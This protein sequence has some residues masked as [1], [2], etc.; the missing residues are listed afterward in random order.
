MTQLFG[1]VL[2]C[3]LLSSSGTSLADVWSDVIKTPHY[4]EQNGSWQL[5]Y[6]LYEPPYSMIFELDMVPPVVVYLHGAP[7]LVDLED[8]DPI[9]TDL[10]LSGCVV[11]MPFYGGF[12]DNW[13]RDAANKTRQALDDI[14]NRRVGSWHPPVSNLALV[15]H[16]MG[17]MFAVKMAHDA[18][19]LQFPSRPRLVVLH[20][21]AGWV[22]QWLVNPEPGNTYWYDNLSG[23]HDQASLVLIAAQETWKSDSMNWFQY[24]SMANGSGVW[25]RAW[26]HTGILAGKSAYLVPGDHFSVCKPEDAAAYQAYRDIT[27]NALRS[28]FGLHWPVDPLGTLRVDGWL[29][30]LAP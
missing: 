9:L 21:A 25:S 13:Y 4:K 29:E 3:S 19:R 16:S 22:W 7:S 10:A 23:I 8:Y 14:A 20:D 24:W 27:V 5:Q 1:L 15:G 28:K 17:G 30:A 11:V 18:Q 26:H 12:P 6:L 2:G